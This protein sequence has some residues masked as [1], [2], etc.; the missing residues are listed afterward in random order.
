[1]QFT[2]STVGRKVLM[3]VTGFILISFVGVHLLGNS[4][5][6]WGA[7]GINAYAKHLHDLGPLVWIF[8]LVMLTVFGL[9]IIFGIQLTLE[10]RA[11]NPENYAVKRLV[12]A[13][14]A[15]ETM[16]V[17]GLVILAF[18]VYHLLHFTIHVTNPEISASHL[19]VDAMSRPDVFSM[20]VLSFQKFLISLIYVAAMVF[21]FLHV[22]HGFQSFIQTF[23]LNNGPSL[24]VLEK[25]SKGVALVLLFGYISIPILIIF[26]I[27][28]I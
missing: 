25:V 21:L 23:G 1:M 27:V 6:Y 22:S 18:V 16:I 20:V 15:S 5:V 17:S 24:S 2:Q 3:A 10:N 26:G 8:R 13:N 12:R 14:F 7:D 28:K 11:A 9:H 19:P 4:S